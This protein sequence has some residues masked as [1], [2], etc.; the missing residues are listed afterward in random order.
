[1]K[2]RRSLCFF[3]GFLA[4]MIAG[5]TAAHGEE[6]EFRR[7]YTLNPGATVSL[8]NISGDIKIS[9]WGSSQA[10]LTA[11]KTG[12]ADQ[13]DDVEISIDAQQSRLNIRTVYPKHSNN[14]VSV[15]YDLKVPNDVNLDSISSVSGSIDL[16]DIDNRVIARTVSGDIQAAH[17]G[18]ETSLESVSGD[19]RVTD[20]GGRTSVKSVSG[21][22]TA[23]DIKGD[24]EAKAVSGNI[25]IRQ[26]QG[27]I[28]ADNVSGSININDSDPTSLTASTVSGGVRFEGRLN[29]NGRYNLKSHSGTV[30]ISLPSDS[31]FVLTAS[32][33]SGSIDS[34]FDIKVNSWTQKKTISG[35]VGSG[36]PTVEARSFSGSVR[37][38]HLNMR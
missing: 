29:A 13:L 15:R 31:N 24:L 2:G 11:V 6:K 1:M 5:H 20:T 25:Q 37:I 33:F 22:I 26:V 14:R 8:A 12:P 28:K 17:L 34:D 19:V 18:D 9:S 27:Y 23:D 7:S 36:G 10:E 4:F 32:T 38:Q 35:V 21:A 16:A 3:I 30:Q